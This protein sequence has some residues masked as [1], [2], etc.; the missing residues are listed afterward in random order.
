MASS[1][2]GRCTIEGGYDHPRYAVLD[3]REILRMENNNN[4][5][6]GLVGV[7]II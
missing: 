2:Y 7:L 6:V 5:G 1:G 3:Q 4:N